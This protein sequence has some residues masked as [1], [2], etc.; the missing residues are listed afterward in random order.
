MYEV[1]GHIPDFVT[2]ST[3]DAN[4]GYTKYVKN[5]DFDPS[6]PQD[7]STNYPKK[8][9]PRGKRWKLGEPY[10]EASIKVKK[11]QPKKK[12]SDELLEE[13]VD[14]IEMMKGF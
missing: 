13:L 6:K 14:E 10:P 7:F 9:V 1:V 12:Y 8:S 4:C 11:E 3:T 5:P 2:I